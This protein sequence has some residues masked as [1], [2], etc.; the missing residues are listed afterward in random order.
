MINPHKLYAFIDRAGKATYAGGGS[1]EQNPQRPGFNELVYEELPWVYR[2][3]YTGFTRSGGQEIVTFEIKPVWW[4]GYGGGMTAGNESKASETFGFLKICLSQDEPGF[5]SLR[6]PHNFI[7]GNWKYTYT[8]GGDITDFSGLENIY[9]RGK[10]VFF[11]RAI[12]GV[13]IK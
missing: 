13:V 6:G 7:Q 9:F 3:S 2:D 12:G 11:H 8:Q 4:S 5:S 1:S 10:L